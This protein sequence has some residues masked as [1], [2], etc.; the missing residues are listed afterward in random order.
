MKA[1]QSMAMDATN[2]RDVLIRDI[3]VSDQPIEQALVLR[4][5]L[6]CR[7]AV[8]FRRSAENEPPLSLSL[9]VEYPHSDMAVQSAA[10]ESS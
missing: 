5:S 8:P 9:R 10:V 7:G 4:E 2:L 1:K 3:P 6:L